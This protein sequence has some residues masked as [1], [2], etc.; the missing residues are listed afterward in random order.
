MFKVGPRVDKWLGGIAS[1]DKKDPRPFLMPGVRVQFAPVALP[2]VRAGK[3][4]GSKVMSAEGDAE[5]I[6]DAYSYEVIRR[7][8]VAWEG[9]VDDATEEPIPVTPETV[10]LALADPDFFAAADRVYVLPFA[11]QSAEKNGFAV[12]PSGTGGA[13]TGASATAR[14]HAARRKA[15]AAKS[16]PTPSKRRKPTRGKKSGGS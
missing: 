6:G 10:E 15:T 9:V 3:A 1:T 11:R 7:G 12:S 4:A 5:E 13:V 14:S 2:A 8:I 16:A